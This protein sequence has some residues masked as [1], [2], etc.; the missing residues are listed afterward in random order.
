VY[1][2]GLG[3]HGEP[4]AK[5]LKW[6]KATKVLERMLEMLLAGLEA[7]GIN[8]SGSNF[9]LL[10]NNLG[11]V[12]PMEMTFLAQVALTMLLKNGVQ[13][14]HVQIGP[15]MTSLDMNGF[16][17]SLGAYPWNTKNPLLGETNAPA[18]V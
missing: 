13:V 3:I 7:R 18:W 16:S 10:V 8:K 6:E 14:T 5:K 4:G 12:P 17:L 15:L 11:A 1:E 9:N 2:L